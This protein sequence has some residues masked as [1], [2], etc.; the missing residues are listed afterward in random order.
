MVVLA[1]DVL[2]EATVVVVVVEPLGLVVG[3]EMGATVVVVASGRATA[4]RRRTL[5][6]GVGNDTHVRP[7]FSFNGWPDVDRN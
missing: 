2:V 4:P 7:G 5:L 3:V 1:S 6:P